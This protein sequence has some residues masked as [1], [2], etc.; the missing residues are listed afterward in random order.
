[1]NVTL[2]YYDEEMVKSVKSH[3]EQYENMTLEE[4]KP[5]NTF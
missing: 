5:K 1:M 3:C 4:L 2:L